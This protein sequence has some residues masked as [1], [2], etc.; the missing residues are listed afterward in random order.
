MSKRALLAAVLRVALL[1][2]LLAMP[3]AATQR[4]GPLQLSGNLQTLNIIRHPDQDDYQY[5]MNRNVVHL[6]LDYDWMQGG[7]FY[8]K[9]DVPFLDRSHL[10][11]LYRG[12]YDSVYDTTPGFIQK[13]DIH[14]NAYGV[15]RQNLYGFAKQ[16]SEDFA[17]ANPRLRN[18]SNFARN[19]L[20]LDGLTREERN[21]LRFDNQLREAYVDLKFRGIPLTVRAGRQQIV[22]GEADNFR[23]LDRANTL[24]LT[25]HF[26]QELP[27]PAYGWD[28]I[29]RPFWMF[30]F[31]YDLGDVWRLSQSFIEWYWNPGDWYPAKQAFLPRP[32][33]LPFL[34][35]LTNPVDGVFFGGPCATS[36]FTVR[37]G[38]N[39]GD[40]RC[41]S[42]LNN[43]ELFEQG[44]YNRD[45]L[46]N[47]QV[48]VRYHG[49]APF[50]LEF[51]LVYFY[52]RFGGDDGSNYAPLRGLPK[53]DRNATLTSQLAQRGI[54]PAE[55]YMPYIHTVGLSANY[56]DEAYTQ[57]VFRAE[58]IYDVG[59]PFF[60]V[61]KETTIDRPPLPG[62]TRKNMW[63]GMLAFDRPTWVRTLNKKSTIFLTGQF[64]WHYLIDNPSCDVPGTNNSGAPFVAVLSSE[65]KRQVGSCL[66]G[67]LDLPSLPRLGNDLAN[68]SAFRDK[69]RDW[70]AI[71][72]FAAFTFYR[73]GS[74]V[75]VIGTAVDPVNQYSMEAFW[76]LDY[77]LRDDFVVNLA[78][79]YFITPKGHHE[80][81]F[82]SWGLA[83][84]HNG[85]SETEIRLTYQF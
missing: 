74:I 1:S 8:G 14:G 26:I 84:M 16:Q 81:I 62:V 6:R 75:P 77:V 79:R 20:T 52:Q 22:W 34:N 85:R 82:E 11:V 76:T 21:I 56:S 36:R 63:K 45:P 51:T 67:G 32:W 28:A 64:F 7:K 68:M 78:Q 72:T 27:P 58:T 23:M 19:T 42:L 38:P 50:G 33:G 2:T 15:E 4:F 24:D 3:A 18:A 29:R 30:K 59:I 37:R 35:P 47:S 40:N 70:E 5:I 55:A 71:F 49:I 25:W 53:N 61:A 69:I 41:V 12:V 31:L 83:G 10:F 60:D 54:F 57:A 43:T 17:R 46:D 48:G 39:A 65:R 9:Y 73:G 66:A 13:T 44:D 80:P